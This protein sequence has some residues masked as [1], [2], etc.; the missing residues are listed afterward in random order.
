[1]NVPDFQREYVWQQ[2]N[3]DRLLDDVFNEFCGEDNRPINDAEYFVG[4]IVVCLGEDGTY[5]LIDGQQRMTTSFLILCAIRDYLIEANA[6][7]PEALKLQIASVSTNLQTGEDEFRYR[8]ALQY[9]DSDHELE[10]IASR[11]TPI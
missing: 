1:M 11:R 2:D 9:E 3:V 10:R 5:Q 6:N 8:L 4:S 7:V